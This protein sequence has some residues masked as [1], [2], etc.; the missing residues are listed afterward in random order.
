M[1]AQG[2]WSLSLLCLLPHQ[3]VQ[4][5][6]G[7]PWDTVLSILECLSWATLDILSILYLIQSMVEI[8]E[9]LANFLKNVHLHSDEAILSF[10]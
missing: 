7:H 10:V 1:L 8:L 5:A 6:L 2:L 4:P 9:V 3:L